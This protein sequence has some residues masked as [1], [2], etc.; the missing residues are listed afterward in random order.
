ML[1]PCCTDAA[2]SR[3]E[4]TLHNEIVRRQPCS[5]QYALLARLGLVGSASSACPAW[6]CLYQGLPRL[7]RYGFLLPLES[8][9]LLL[10]DTTVSLSQDVRP[11]QQGF[12]SQ[13]TTATPLVVIPRRP[14]AITDLVSAYRWSIA[15]WPRYAMRCCD[16]LASMGP[17]W[18]LH[19][20]DGPVG[21][22]RGAGPPTIG[23]LRADPS[24]TGQGLRYS[25][26]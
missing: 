2:N 21:C 1:L 14:H 22:G 3:V 13:Q 8:W 19:M 15:S 6:L 7:Q 4:C 24:G 16:P 26:P 20:P 17:T 12:G 25:V 23:N 10:A 11:E 18:Q 5:H 9:K